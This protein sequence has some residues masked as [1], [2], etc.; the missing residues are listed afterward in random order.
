MELC[1]SNMINNHISAVDTAP[2]IEAAIKN[3]RLSPTDTPAER[4]SI[5]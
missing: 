5:Y 4:Y 2:N 1:I 3:F